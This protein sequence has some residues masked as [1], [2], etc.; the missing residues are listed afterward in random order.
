MERIEFIPATRSGK[1]V[2][3]SNLRIADQAHNLQLFIMTSQAYFTMSPDANFQ[4][5]ESFLRENKFETH[6]IATVPKLNKDFRVLKPGA[7]REESKYECI[8]SCRPAPLA[9]KELLTHWKTYEENFEAL[10]NSG[11]V[12]TNTMPVEKVAG[13]ETYSLNDS[14]R[15]LGEAIRN[16]KVE[17]VKRTLSATE[18]LINTRNGIVQKYGKEPTQIIV[19]IKDGRIPVFAFGIDGNVVSKLIFTTND[20]DHQILSLP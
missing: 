1:D 16:N 6:L 14:E 4:N 8:Y 19:G 12:V 17:F 15:S 5:F 7:T 20:G 2:F 9:L 11:S 3:L 18:V 10:I 13:R